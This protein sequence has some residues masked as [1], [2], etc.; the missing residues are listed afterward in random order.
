MNAT[1]K[2]K[3]FGRFTVVLDIESDCRSECDIWLGNHSIN[4]TVVEC[5]GSSWGD[6]TTDLLLN[7]ILESG[8]SQEMI[9]WAYSEG[10]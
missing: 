4:M 3:K 9:D 7:Q 1:T 2:K 8:L 6:E 5:G 10:Y